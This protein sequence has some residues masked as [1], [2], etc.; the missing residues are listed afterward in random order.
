MSVI[1]ELKMIER[2]EKTMEKEKF[3]R[4]LKVMNINDP[5]EDME[6]K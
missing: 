3:L 1:K 4:D 6:N 5:A 2:G